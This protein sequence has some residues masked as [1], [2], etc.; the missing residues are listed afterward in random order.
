MRSLAISGTTLF[1]GTNGAGVYSSVAGA[2]WAA[3]GGAPAFLGGVTSLAAAGAQV[4]AGSYAG[5]GLY[6]SSSAGGSWSTASA[7]I[8][9]ADTTALAISADASELFAVA[10]HQLMRSLNH[11]ATWQYPVMSGLSYPVVATAVAV[12]P[13]SASVVYVGSNGVRRSTDGGATFI[14]TSANF[15]PS[16]LAIPAQAHNLVYAAVFNG[17]V[18]SADFSTANSTWKQVNNGISDLRIRS[19]AVDPANAKNLFA[20]GDGGFFRSTD[21]GASWTSSGLTFVRSITAAAGGKVFAVVGAAT[22]SNLQKSTNGGASFTP[23]NFGTAAVQNLVSIAVDSTTGSTLYAVGNSSNGSEGGLYK[24][25]DGG[26][27]WKA[28]KPGLSS[29]RLRKLLIDPTAAGSLYLAS[30]DNGVLLSSSA[31]E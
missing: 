26:T 1:A 20:G 19:V 30:Q 29:T 9:A 3:T 22:S 7:G 11:G 17:G 16:A 18:Y 31:G 28:I 21:G 25:I 8:T 15:V 14:D 23:V 27:S 6:Y 10:G 5:Q 12:D 4:L 24:S 13:S 2:A